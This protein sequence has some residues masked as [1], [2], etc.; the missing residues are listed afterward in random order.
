[1]CSSDLAAGVKVD[2]V[3]PQAQRIDAPADGIREAGDT[4][5]FS[6][7]FDEAVTLT[8]GT[9]ALQF[10]L[11]TQQVLA[12]YVSG[13]GGT[14]LQ[15]SLTLPAGVAE[16]DLLALNSLVLGGARLEDAAG[17]AAAGSL[18]ALPSL[19]GI[20]FGDGDGIASAIENLVPTL[21]QSGQFGDGNADGTADRLQPEVVSG[22]VERFG[23]P[24]DNTFATLAL[25]STGGSLHAVTVMPAPDN[26]GPEIVVPFGVFGFSATLATAGARHDF[27][28]FVPANQGVNSFWLFDETAGWLLGEAGGT[29]QG[30]QLRFDFSVIDGA[31]GDGDGLVNG[32][33]V[34]VGGAAF[35]P[36]A[37]VTEAV[38]A[39]D[40]AGFGH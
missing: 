35:V 25:R 19:A 30:G 1:V 8:G 40:P 21:G 24:A 31:V 16:G 20:R 28:V 12:A 6:L 36:L 5:V 11:G 13:S 17:N 18:P 33:I 7:H 38:P 15:F 32:E 10:D 27:S 2:G 22:P 34:L 39:A 9:P 26:L 29:R 23:Q 4:L 14:T 3:A 37:G